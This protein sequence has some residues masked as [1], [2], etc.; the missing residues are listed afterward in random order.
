[1]NDPVEPTAAARR[2]RAKQEQLHT[3]LAVEELVAETAQSRQAMHDL[4]ASV[5]A[6]KEARDR[7][8][9]ALERS[10]E[11]GRTLSWI[12]LAAVVFMVLLGVV[13]ALNLNNARRNAKA[14]ADIA[15]ATA[16][17]NATL[18]DCLN[19]RG[20]CG[21]LSAQNQRQAVDNIKLYDLTVIYC[22]R[23]NPQPTDPKG[24]KFIQ[25]IT[26]LYPTGPVL[27]RKDE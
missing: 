1:M 4:V 22:A 23:T 16:Q 21:K 13:N 12:G 3:E 10:Y 14:T 5:N 19:V 27:D 2:A 26:K 15:R 6:E 7:K 8:V 11:Q 18:A 25:C 17:T 20:E 9:A 24:D